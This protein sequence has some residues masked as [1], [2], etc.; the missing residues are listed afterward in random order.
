VVCVV[1]AIGYQLVIGV[2]LLGSYADRG[3]VVFFL[4]CW[5]A[6]GGSSW[7]D[8]LTWAGGPDLLQGARPACVGLGL[9]GIFQSMLL[10]RS[11]FRSVIEADLLNDRLRRQVDDLEER[12]SEIETLNEELRRQIGRRTADVL[13]ALTDS[14][15]ALDITLQA[16]DIVEGRYRVVRALGVGGM[17]A[18]YEVERVNDGKRLALKLAQEVRGLALARLA[19]EA[20]IASQI[21]H[22]NVVSIVDA[23][24]AQGG[25]AYLVM[26]L[27]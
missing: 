27:W 21:H 24:V 5:L 19:R 13:A 22:P 17:G 18:V 1:A 3:I 2:R 26:E 11:H 20:R 16:G 15:R 4:C 7:V 12:G 8:L 14:D 9:F 10:S 6:L 23:D 25:Y